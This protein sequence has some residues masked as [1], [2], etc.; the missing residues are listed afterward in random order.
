MVESYRGV[1]SSFD[2]V[3]LYN[4]RLC[5]CNAGRRVLG[6]VPYHE[7]PECGHPPSLYPETCDPIYPRCLFC[8][9][10][11][12]FLESVNAHHASCVRHHPLEIVCA[13]MDLAHSD[14]PMA[15]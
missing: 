4:H 2:G 11:A 5:A 1:G 6:L 7:N 10:R 8:V 9:C 12:L 14:P 13:K 15:A 3:R